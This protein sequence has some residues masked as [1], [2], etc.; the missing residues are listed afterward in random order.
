MSR[1]LLFMMILFL[2]LFFLVSACSNNS[3][4][5]EADPVRIKIGTREISYEKL[6]LI[7]KVLIF[8][9]D[10]PQF[11]KSETPIGKGRCSLCHRLLPEQHADR[12]P[13]LLGVEALSHKRVKE[14]RYQMFVDRYSADGD[15]ETGTKPHAK[16]GGEYL[17]ESLYCPRCY[18]AKDHGIKGTND[19]ES[20]MPVI[21]RSP[22]NLTDFEI[23]AVVAYLQSK[24]TP[25]DYSKVTAIE[26]W[27]SYF[28]KKIT[29][30]PEE[31]SINK[32]MPAEPEPNK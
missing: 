23:V 29:F 9:T 13:F 28:G 6:A 25:G 4:S 5:T 7:G 8:G 1:I 2:N 22:V 21:T 17:I 14:E 27:E 3:P 24:D 26:D 11:G 31:A 30:T 12:A 19:L 16:T 32:Y 15:P 18:V 10:N 20:G